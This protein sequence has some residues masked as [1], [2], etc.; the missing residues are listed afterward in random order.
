MMHGQQILKF[1]HDMSSVKKTAFIHCSWSHENEDAV[2][3]YCSSF[4]YP[5]N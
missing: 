4:T 5:M 2:T 1:C 3:K